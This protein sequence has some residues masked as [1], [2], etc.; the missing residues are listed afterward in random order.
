MPTGSRQ[1]LF[2]FA[3]EHGH[4]P[5]KVPLLAPETLCEGV[6]LLRS[7]AL[8]CAP[9]LV[10]AIIGVI[11]AAPLRH[12]RTPGGRRLSV[13]S[14]NCGDLGWVSNARGYH[15]S[16]FDEKRRPW[17]AMPP[18]FSELAAKAAAQAG[19]PDKP[20]GPPF[21]PDAC[22]IHRYKVGARMGLHQ[23]RDELDVDQ[24][25]VS[26]SLGLSAIFLLGGARRSD[27][28]QRLPLTH[29]DVLVWGG[30]ARLYFHGVLPIRPGSHAQLGAQRLALTLRRAG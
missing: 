3:S 21:R 27:P 19:F 28:R 8:S 23:D 17:P 14:T 11:K 26:I 12:M 16:R 25:I 6:T 7:F 15:Y 13:A 10:R 29:G 2:D 22:L 5:A 4:P 24:P 18:I 1:E 20:S 9:Q 30:P